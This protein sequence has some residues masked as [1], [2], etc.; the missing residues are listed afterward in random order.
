MIRYHYP[1]QYA[2]SVPSKIPVMAGTPGL[3][4]T[5]SPQLRE[6]PGH[7][8]REMAAGAGMYRPVSSMDHPWIIHG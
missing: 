1:I 2:W 7:D 4:T 3:S 5:L 8:M 6:L